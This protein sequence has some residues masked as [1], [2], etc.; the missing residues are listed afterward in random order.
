MVL[1]GFSKVFFS[2]DK[3]FSDEKAFG[4]VDEL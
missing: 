2:Q 3:G 4:V 1:V